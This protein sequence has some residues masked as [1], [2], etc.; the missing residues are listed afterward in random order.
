MVEQMP[1]AHS[2]SYT[3]ES[4]SKWNVWD[5]NVKVKPNFK[6]QNASHLESV[7]AEPGSIAKRAQS[8]KSGLQSQVHLISRPTEQ[9]VDM[10]RIRIGTREYV[11]HRSTVT[12]LQKSRDG[13]ARALT[14]HPPRQHDAEKVN[15]GK[16]NGAN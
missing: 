13:N 1:G 7:W 8:V 12:K 2:Q 16:V 14:N 4:M 11:S 15:G 9:A 10:R 5:P 6:S 3:P